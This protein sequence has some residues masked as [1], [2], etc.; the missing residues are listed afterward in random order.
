MVVIHA[1]ATVLVY[2]VPWGTPGAKGTMNKQDLAERLKLRFIYMRTGI[3]A[4]YDQGLP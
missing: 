3:H 2:L 1:L 4:G